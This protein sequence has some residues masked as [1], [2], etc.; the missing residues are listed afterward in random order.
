MKV[1]VQTLDSKSNGDIELNDE[2]FAVEPRADILHRVVTW[3]LE[4]R[5]GTARAARE[6]SDVARTGKKFGRQKGGGTARHGDRRAPI[7]IG[8]GKAHGPRVR[9]FNPSLN[10]KVRALGL[11]MALSSK[12][13]SGQLVVVDNL[14]LKEGKTRELRSKLDGL[15]FGKTALVIDGDALNVSFAHASSNLGS[16][17]LMPA[18]GANVYDIMRHET[19]VLTRAAIEKLEARFNG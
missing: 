9:D 3:Q 15:G 1:K 4:K 12:A 10:K 17:N 11:R 2:I 16:I 5:R 13:Q 7:F 6:R 19:L 14:D 18:V 8:G